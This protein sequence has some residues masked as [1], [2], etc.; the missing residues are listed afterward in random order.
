MN[1]TPSWVHRPS[2]PPPSLISNPHIYQNISE[3]SS[4]PHF[5]FLSGPFLQSARP[6][7]LASS[8]VLFSPLLHLPYSV[9]HLS[10]GK[11]P[12]I[13]SFLS[14]SPAHSVVSSTFNTKTLLYFSLEWDWVLKPQRPWFKFW[15]CHL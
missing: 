15:L 12:W 4:L 10:L 1:Y 9:C 7:T 8:G 6:T 2:S 5:S 11:T 13:H 3:N 14:S